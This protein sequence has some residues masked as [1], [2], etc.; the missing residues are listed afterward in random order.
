[1]GT[2]WVIKL[3]I[4][5][6]NI[7]YFFSCISISFKICLKVAWLYLLH[8]IFFQ[9]VLLCLTN[10]KVNQI[11][12]WF[13]SEHLQRSHQVFTLHLVWDMSFPLSVGEKKIFRLNLSEFLSDCNRSGTKVSSVEES[14]CYLEGKSSHS[15]R[16]IKKIENYLQ[17]EGNIYSN[18]VSHLSLLFCIILNLWCLSV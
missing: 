15:V 2:I 10:E 1:M 3:D 13:K 5:V 17:R 7:S 14:G 11:I 4:T 18:N 6:L 16:S 9:S 8:F 12:Y